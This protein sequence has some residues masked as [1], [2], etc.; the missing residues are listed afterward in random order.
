[1]IRSNAVFIGETSFSVETGDRDQENS[2]VDLHWKR[3]IF[4]GT[5]APF[6]F[7][8]VQLSPDKK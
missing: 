1:M 2:R 7:P 5:L 3:E 6:H 8:F 4:L